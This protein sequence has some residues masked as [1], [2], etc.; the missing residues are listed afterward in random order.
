[1]VSPYENL[2]RDFFQNGVDFLK[3]VALQI[4]INDMAFSN[5]HFKSKK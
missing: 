3:K 4:F 5:D 1:M 2:E